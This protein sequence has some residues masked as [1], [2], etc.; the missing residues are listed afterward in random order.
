MNALVSSFYFSCDWC[1]SHYPLYRFA[2]F[3]VS[4]LAIVLAT[5]SILDC[6]GKSCVSAPTRIGSEASAEGLAN[7]GHWDKEHDV[8]VFGINRGMTYIQQ[9]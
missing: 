9:N 5:S 3:H 6:S 4:I 8:C 7:F 2:V 1:Q